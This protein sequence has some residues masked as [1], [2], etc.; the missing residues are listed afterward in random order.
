[1]PVGYASGGGGGGTLGGFLNSG[2]GRA[3]EIG[4]GTGSART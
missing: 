2:F 1:M 3:M 4:A